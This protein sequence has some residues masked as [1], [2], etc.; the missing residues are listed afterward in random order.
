V[1]PTPDGGNEKLRGTAPAFPLA[2]DK[3]D[4][5]PFE[6]TLYMDDYGGGLNRSMQH[7]LKDLLFKDGVYDPE[8]T[9][10]ALCRA[11]NG[12]METVE[13]RAVVA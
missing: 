4:Y 8:E 5:H 2:P 3:S 11:E 7:H 6:V 12:D 13:G 1:S 10:E 9:F